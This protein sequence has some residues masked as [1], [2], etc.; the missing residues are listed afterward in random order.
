MPHRCVGSLL[1]GGP[2]TT[3]PVRV[4][5]IEQVFPIVALIGAEPEKSEG[6]RVQAFE[7]AEN[8]RQLVLRQGGDAPARP[9]QMLCQE[10]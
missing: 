9:A 7:G 5:G 10:E 1:T 2:G 6:F 4:Q 8:F 3:S